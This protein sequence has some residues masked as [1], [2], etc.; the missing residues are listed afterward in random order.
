MLT[1]KKLYTLTAIGTATMVMTVGNLGATS[2]ASTQASPKDP[3]ASSKDIA[4]TTY[5]TKRYEIDTN[6]SYE[7]FVARFETAVPMVSPALWTGAADW[8]EVVANTAAAATMGS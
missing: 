8:D 6:Q 5:A 2:T 1:S 3:G 4:V 7:E